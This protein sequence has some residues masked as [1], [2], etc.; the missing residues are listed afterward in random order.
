MPVPATQVAPPSVL[1]CQVAPGSSPLTV[2]VP[3]LVIPS[4]GDR[5]VSTASIAAGASGKVVSTVTALST[6]GVPTLPAAS[7]CRTSTVPAA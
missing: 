5:P 2:T 1:Y 3:L 4:A 7:A 6:D